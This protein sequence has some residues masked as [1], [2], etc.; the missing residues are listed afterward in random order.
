MQTPDYNNKYII[1]SCSVEP[2]CTRDMRY[3]SIHVTLY[4]PTEFREE[5]ERIHHTVPEKRITA[6]YHETFV[7]GPLH[8]VV[9][10]VRHMNSEDWVA[11]IETI[12]V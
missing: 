3:K 8:D 12:Y 9:N 6:T 11:S 4:V 2:W 10:E 7:D 1:A 5:Y